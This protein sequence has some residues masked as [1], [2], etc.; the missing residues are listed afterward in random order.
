MACGLFALCDIM[1]RKRLPP[2]LRQAEFPPSR[3][4]YTD[5]TERLTKVMKNRLG[6]RM[7]LSAQ[8]FFVSFVRFVVKNLLSG[9]RWL[10]PY[11]ITGE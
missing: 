3:E 6:N 9:L 11:R 1:Q 7:N 8:I 4:C 2:S 10:N 5:K